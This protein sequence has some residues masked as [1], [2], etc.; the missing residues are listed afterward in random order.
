MENTTPPATHRPRILITNDDGIAA[1]GLQH[2]ADFVADFGEVRVVAPDS[3]RS[4]QSGAITVNVPLR[5]TPQ[6]SRG[7][8]DFYSCNGTPVDCIKL[9]LHC[10]RDFRPDLILSGINHG[11]NAAISILYSGTM[12]AVLEGCVVGVPSIGFSLCSHDADANFAPSRE[13][14]REICRNVLTDGLPPKVCLNVNIPVAPARGIRVCRQARGHWSEEYTAHPTP[15]RVTDY[16]LAGFF[17]NEEPDARDTDE[18]FLAEG[19]ASV[20]PCTY[21][22]TARDVISAMCRRFDR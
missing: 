13:I 8:I 19:Y 10:F 15:D 5:L 20:V 22:Q 1:K 16:R 9:A 6:P 2:L 7:G 14:V 3:A 11:H 21:D 4:G 12:G 17:V 18:Y